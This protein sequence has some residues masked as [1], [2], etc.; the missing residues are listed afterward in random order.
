MKLL[1]F[2]LAFAAIL[3]AGCGSRGQIM[4]GDG[5]LNSYHQ[6]TQEEAMYK[7]VPFQIFCFDDEHGK[8][9]ERIHIFSSSNLQLPKDLFVLDK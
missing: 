5:M 8:T 9:L 6:I 2:I 4:D 7:D 3:L 1:Y